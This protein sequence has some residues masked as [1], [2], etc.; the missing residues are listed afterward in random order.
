[1][2]GQPRSRTAPLG[3]STGAR[4]RLIEAL[5]DL[6]RRT[7]RPLTKEDIADEVLRVTT[8]VA[9]DGNELIGARAVIRWLRDGL[10]VL[11]YDSVTRRAVDK[12]ASALGVDGESGSGEPS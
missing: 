5:H 12:L 1:M 10:H 9:F 7:P 8:V 2:T 4:E 6:D 3:R 11:L